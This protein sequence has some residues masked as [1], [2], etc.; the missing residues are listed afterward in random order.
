LRW[1]TQT[2]NNLLDIAGTT[3]LPIQFRSSAAG[4]VAY[5]T[6]YQWRADDPARGVTDVWATGQWL[7]PLLTNEGGGG[8]ANRWFGGSAP[9]IGTPIPTLADATLV[10]LA[11]LLAAT[12]AWLVRRRSS[13]TRDFNRPR[14]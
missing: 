7:A 12:G 3:A 14:R 2:V 10:A 1:P 9:V 13:S 6:C 11:A 5:I 4:Q 8:N